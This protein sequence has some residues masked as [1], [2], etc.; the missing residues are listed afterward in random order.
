MKLKYIFG[1][2]LSRRLGKSLGIDLIPF[3]TCSLDCVYCECGK[4]D[5]LT[6]ERKEYVPTE[7]VINELKKYL[8]NRPKLDYI[9]FSGSGE[10]TLHKGIGEIISFLKDNYPEYKVAL[11]TNSTLLYRNQVISEIKGCDLIVPSLD[12]VSEEIFQKINRPVSGLNAELI[13]KG[14]I[15]LRKNYNGK[16]WLE[17]FIIPDLNDN[18]KELML[19][20]EA[21]NRIKPDKIQLNVLDRPGTENWVKRI[22]EE[23]L[24][25]IAE[26][27]GDNVEVIT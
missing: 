24:M 14:L 22:P 18:K 17:I 15:N 10:P 20:K 4:T 1:P 26:Y 5:K 21:I 9:T 25:E 19:F 11:L 27:L 23:R 13:V 16:M 2:V 7:E 12:A 3:K 6:L 8:Y